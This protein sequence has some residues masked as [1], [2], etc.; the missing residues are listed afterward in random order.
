VL[1]ARLAISELTLEATQAAVLHAGARGYISASPVNRL[2]REGNFVAL[3]T[4]SVRHLRQELAKP[5]RA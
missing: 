1:R 4:P 3:I 5:D 2:Q